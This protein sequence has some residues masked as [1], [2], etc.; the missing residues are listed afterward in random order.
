MTPIR[1]RSIPAGT[2]RGAA[3]LLALAPL[4][5]PALCHAAI[6]SA[7]GPGGIRLLALAGGWLLLTAFLFTMLRRA[8]PLTRYLAT[9]LFF[10]APLLWLT[11]TYHWFMATDPQSFAAQRLGA[12]HETD[13]PVQLGGATFPAG[14]RVQMLVATGQPAALTSDRAVA[15]GALSIRGIEHRD[16]DTDAVYRATLAFD[17]TVDG[18][19]CAAI[20]ETGTRVDV[21]DPH[22]PKPRLLQCQLAKTVN[23]GDIAWPPATI[24]ARAPDGAGWALRWSLETYSQVGYAKGFSFNVNTMSGD[25]DAARQLTA[26]QGRLAVDGDVGVGSVTFAG[27]PQPVL[28]WQRGDNSVQ[29]TGRRSGAPAQAADACVKVASRPLRYLPCS[30][31]TPAKTPGKAP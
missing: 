24:V 8:R 3:R 5:A 27:N 16:G 6:G 22:A 10:A 21:G 1:P 12:S 25:Y 2:L 7:G 18:W 14:S 9:A 28:R 19:P 17:Q 26:W 13:A 20:S 15:L 30:G 31:D 29:V 4:L 23:L 11:A